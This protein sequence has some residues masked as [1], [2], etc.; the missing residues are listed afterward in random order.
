[1]ADLCFIC[2]ESLS[3][4]D[5]ANVV[6]GL[7]TLKAA[8]IERNDGHIDFLNSSTP[9]NTNSLNRLPSTEKKPYQDNK[10]SEA[11]ADIFNYIE[12][13]DDSQFTLKEFRDV[14]MGKLAC[15]DIT[16]KTGDVDVLILETAIEESE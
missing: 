16:T 5:P 8:S 2:D 14:L 13:H 15:V 1:M 11:M 9:E 4:G 10:V 7:K 12:N 3:Q 6:R